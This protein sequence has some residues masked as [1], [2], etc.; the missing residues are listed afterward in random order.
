MVVSSCIRLECLITEPICPT[1]IHIELDWHIQYVIVR[2]RNST[3]NCPSAVKYLLKSSRQ[4][5]NWIMCLLC[6]LMMSCIFLCSRSQSTS[7][8]SGTASIY[9]FNSR[10][11]TT[12][13]YAKVSGPCSDSSRL[14]YVF[15][16][17]YTFEYTSS[18]FC[19]H[20]TLYV[21]DCLL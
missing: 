1:A 5:S 2:N 14:P 3:S 10:I 11:F 19:V 16:N 7:T 21:L 6:K 15:Q 8:W 13:S 20:V 4:N 17:T 9:A 18:M 12:N